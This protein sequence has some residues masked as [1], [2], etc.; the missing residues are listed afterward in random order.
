LEGWEA[1]FFVKNIREIWSILNNSVNKDDLKKYQKE[2]RETKDTKKL[3]ATQ[4]NG[5][6][7]GRSPLSF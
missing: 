1:N 6:Q 4:K 7:H 5:K 2:M 3:M